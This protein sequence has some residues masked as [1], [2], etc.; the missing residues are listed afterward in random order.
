MAASKAG[1]AGVPKTR[2]ATTKEENEK[3]GSAKKLQDALNG[4][5]SGAKAQV[6]NSQANVVGS[7]RETEKDQS[8]DTGIESQ[9]KPPYGLPEDAHQSDAA[10]PKDTEMGETS[11]SHSEGYLSSDSEQKSS[12][13]NTTSQEVDP[14]LLLNFES[15]TSRGDQQGVVDGF[16]GHRDAPRYFF[17]RTNACSTEGFKSLSHHRISALKYEDD[18]GEMQKFYSRENIKGI[19]GIAIEERDETREYKNANQ[20]WIKIK[21]KGIRKEHKKLLCKLVKDDTEKDRHSSWIPR[22]DLIELIG[23]KATDAQLKGIWNA[24]EER[25]LRGLTRSQSAYDRSP[26]P[27]PLDIFNEQKELRERTRSPS[28]APKRSSSPRAVKQSFEEPQDVSQPRM[29][30]SQ[31]PEPAIKEESEDDPLFVSAEPPVKETHASD[32]GEPMGE[33]K[34]DVDKKPREPLRFSFES[35]VS[36]VS[37]RE[38]WNRMSDDESE[39]RLAAAEARWDHY[40]QKRLQSGDICEDD[41]EEEL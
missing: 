12:K 31:P 14:D 21:W 41:E 11:E 28:V 39:L 10:E 18:R 30:G 35:F 17:E 15:L 5:I 19:S 6:A 16:G 27:F 38:K 20:T 7:T 8:R 26:S 1:T 25:Y 22:A 3:G 4:N 40:K 34:L 9:S 29:T 13:S 33:P 37:K 2:S 36:S 23:R 24:Q 32:P